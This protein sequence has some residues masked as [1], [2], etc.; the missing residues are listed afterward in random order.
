[1]EGNSCTEGLGFE[2]Q[3]HILDEHFS[4]LFVEKVVM[5]VWKDKNKRK[6]D[7]DGPFKKANLCYFPNFGFFSGN[8]SI[9]SNLIKY[10]FQTIT[11]LSWHN[12][13]NVIEIAKYLPALVQ[14]KA[15]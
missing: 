4:H 11:A 3:N 1:M 13:S 15:T 5:L 2:S 7:R 8:R 12:S 9:L 14:L 6:S 10:L